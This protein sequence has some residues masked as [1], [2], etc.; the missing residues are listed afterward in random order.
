MKKIFNKLKYRFLSIIFNR[1]K[2]RKNKYDFE[3]KLESIN[4]SEFNR[5]YLYKYFHHYFWNLSPV[6][7]KEHRTYFSKKQRPRDCELMS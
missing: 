6:W 7:L 3:I 5:N 4:K 1:S 2:N